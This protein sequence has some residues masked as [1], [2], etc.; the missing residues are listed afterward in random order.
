LDWNVSPQEGLEVDVGFAPRCLAVTPASSLLAAG[1]AGLV[2]FD[3]LRSECNRIG[4]SGAAIS[5]V[6]FSPEGRRLLT[7]T[8]NGVVEWWDSGSGRLLLSFDWG[9]GPIS[10][11]AVAPDGATCAAG[12]EAGQ[13]I[14]WDRDGE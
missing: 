7:G 2:L 1:G 12:T 9:C 8:E 14:V 3:P 6:V 13:I 11:V 5:A 10:A 4:R